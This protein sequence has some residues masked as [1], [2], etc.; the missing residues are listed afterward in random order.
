M[1]QGAAF[2]VILCAMLKELS[3]LATWDR[4]L[5]VVAGLAMLLLGWSDLVDG[6]WAIA[7]VVFAWVPLLTGLAGWCPFYAILGISSLKRR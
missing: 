1:W 5:R 7:L 3:N 2:R 6:V 4:A